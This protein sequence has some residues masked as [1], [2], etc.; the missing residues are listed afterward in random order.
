MSEA[1]KRIVGAYVEL[2]NRKALEDAKAHRYRL[3][4]E[5]KLMKCA[6]DLSSTIKQL[7]DDITVIDAGLAELD[8]P[9]WA[10]ALGL[11]FHS[12]VA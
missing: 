4:T 8:T 1:L 9:H 10:A 12:R 2:R 7:E 6:F 11:G 5:L 3:A